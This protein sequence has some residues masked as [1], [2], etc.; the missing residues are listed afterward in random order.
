MNAPAQTITP[1]RQ[2]AASQVSNVFNSVH[3]YVST[4]QHKNE[5]G[6]VLT[7]G[8]LEHARKSIEE[9]AFWVIKHVLAHGVPA[10]PPA[11]AN[12][13]PASNVA[14][15]VADLSAPTGADAQPPTTPTESM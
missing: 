13:A 1:E 4:L 10:A 14:E 15:V 5:A 9:A 8:P 2:I 3:A 6:Q 12:D 11:A 7:S